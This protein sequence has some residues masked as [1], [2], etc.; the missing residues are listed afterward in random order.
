MVAHLQHCDQI[1]DRGNS[2]AVRERL[3]TTYGVNRKS[4]FAHLKDFDICQCFPQDIM[5]ILLEGVVPYES[6]LL[7]KVLI[8]GIRCF[9]LKEL[10]QKIESFD[11]GYM[12]KKNQPSPIT[13]DTMNAVS[14]SKLKQTGKI[15]MVLQ[16]S[17]SFGK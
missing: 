11:Y 8:D 9:T 16:M 4:I 1:E 13:R 2:V 12:N 14:D 6:K 15:S 5:H 10:N 7:L 17:K 3:S